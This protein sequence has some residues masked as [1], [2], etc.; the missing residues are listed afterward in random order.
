MRVLATMPTMFDDR[1]A[2]DALVAQ[3][4]SY[5]EDEGH[6]FFVLPNLNQYPRSC[7]YD[8]PFHLHEPCQIRHSKSLATALRAML[9]RGTP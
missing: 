5:Y 9:R 1:L 2:E 6:V 3:L 4:R 8:T 7:F